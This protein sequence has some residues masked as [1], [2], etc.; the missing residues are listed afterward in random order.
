MG[1]LFYR[2]LWCAIQFVLSIPTI[3]C[4]CH[5]LIEH[6][7]GRIVLLFS[8]RMRSLVFRT[9]FLR[10][11]ICTVQL[12]TS[13]L[14]VCA[15]TNNFVSHVSQSASKSVNPPF[16][17]PSFLPSFFVRRGILLFVF[18]SFAASFQYLDNY[19]LLKSRPSGNVDVNQIRSSHTTWP[20]PSPPWALCWWPTRW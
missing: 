2:L 6:A 12:G 13:H 9:L 18:S 5:E 14:S 16:L 19:E 1:C 20:P 11:R 15:M 4:L 3:L 7:T 8:F 17:L 10:Y